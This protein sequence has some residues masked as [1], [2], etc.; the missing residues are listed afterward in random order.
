MSQ[1]PVPPPLDPAPTLVAE[2]VR[3]FVVP[4]DRATL[5]QLPAATASDPFVL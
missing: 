1:P 5:L 4:F 2:E 3:A